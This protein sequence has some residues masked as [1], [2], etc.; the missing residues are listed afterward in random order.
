MDRQACVVIPV[1]P[2]QLLVHAH[3]DWKPHPIAV[4]DVV[5]AQG[6][7]LWAN[8]SARRHGI[9]DGLRYAAALGLCA[10]LRAGAVAATDIAASVALWV[11]CLRGFTPGVEPC[12]D[13]PGVFW[14]DG[15]GLQ[16]H[17]P[18]PARWLESITAAVRGAGFTAVAVCGYGRFATYAVAKALASAVPAGITRVF[19]DRAAEDAAL[20]RVPLDRIGIAPAALEV[21]SQLGVRTVGAFARLPAAGIRRR[22]DAAT[23]RLH[24]MATG[25]CDLPPQSQAEAQPIAVTADLEPAERDSERL[26]FRIKHHLDPLLAQTAACGRALAALEL[27]LSLESGPA[28][29]H[30][31]RPAAP[32]L[33]AVQLLGLVR[34]ALEAAP[35]PAAVKALALR[36]ES[37]PAR[38]HQDSL[39]AVRPERDRAAAGRALARLR[40]AFGDDAVVRARLADGHLPEAQFAWERVER[41]PAPPHA[42]VPASAKATAKAAMSVLPTA[43][44]APTPAPAPTRRVLVRRLFA[45]PVLLPPRPPQEPDGW[46]LRGLDHGPVARFVGPYV[47]SGAWWRREIQR[48]YYIAEMRAGDLLWIYYDRR[49]RHW[50]LHGIVA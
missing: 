28:R 17:F 9:R 21:L 48:E 47:I 8:A 15:R 20:Q 23:E 45:T 49:R 40:A 46:L 2:L 6:V 31:I 7:V 38:H 18:T 29:E 12:A 25:N 32:T 41:M 42:P 44:P 11:Q 26:V 27:R 24:R 37:V 10:E 35:P 22:F 36:I 43:T 3:P 14:L 1:L 34:L 16:G 30:V 5:T 33:D 50:F 4:V 13:E 19:A 39:F